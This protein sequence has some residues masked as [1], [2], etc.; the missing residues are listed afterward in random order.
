MTVVPVD[1]PTRSKRPIQARSI[2]TFTSILDAAT[3]VVVERGI[4]GLNTNIVAERAGINIG[5]VYHYFPDKTAILL[6]LFRL[7]QQQRAGYLY[8]KYREL[9]TATDLDRWATQTYAL[10]LKLRTEHP[11]TALLRRAYR[12]VPELVKYDEQDTEQWIEF[13]STLLRERFKNLGEVRARLA[14]SVLI[15]TTSAIFD[16]PNAEGRQA[17]A[18][19]AEAVTMLTCY[20]RTLERP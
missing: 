14:A 6:E 13:L 19:L 3:E 7:D 15:E 2:A 18:F 10:A 5:T 16:S 12:S 4:Q 20:L 17:Q 11:A 1:A 9:P 8:D